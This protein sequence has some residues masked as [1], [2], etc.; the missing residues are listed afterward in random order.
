MGFVD[1]IYSL[2]LLALLGLVCYAIWWP[3]SRVYYYFKY[4]STER[5][6]RE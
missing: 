4:G 2:V 1:L 5:R 6:F 3:V